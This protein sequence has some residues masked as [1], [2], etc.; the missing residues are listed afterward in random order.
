MDEELTSLRGKTVIISGGSTGIGRA[1]AVLLSKQECNVVIFARTRS[2]IEDALLDIRKMSGRGAFGFIGDTSHIDDV[3]RIFNLAVIKYKKVDVL[4]NNAGIGGRS[5]VEAD[6]ADIA[7]V[8]NTNF[9]GYV[10]CAKEALKE[11]I[12]QADGHIINIGSLSG[13]FYH[14]DTDIYSATKSAVETFSYTLAQKVNPL[15]IKVTL[16]QPGATGTSMVNEAPEE[17]EKSEANLSLLKAEDVARA[18]YFALSRPKRCHI[19]NIE[20]KSLN[21]II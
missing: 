21:Q 8:I 1:I 6:Y 20:L 19:M 10:N 2:T 16:I 3:K 7:S 18:V 12:P 9:L 17:Q 4:I 13:K 11:M 14:S 5:V 15:G